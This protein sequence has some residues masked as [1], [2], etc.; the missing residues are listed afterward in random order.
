MSLSLLHNVDRNC[1]L[2][3]L[4]EIIQKSLVV[5]LNSNGEFPEDCR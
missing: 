1:K 3:N 5:P 4:A 2:A